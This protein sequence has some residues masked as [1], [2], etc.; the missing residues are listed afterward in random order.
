MRVLLASVFIGMFATGLLHAQD[1]E[2]KVRNDRKNVE[3][4]G[5]W[6]YNDLPKGFS[7]AKKSGKPLLLIIRC[8]PC[9]ACAPA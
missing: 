8:V 1:R 4:D 6:I 2:T 5:Y 7:E 3:G 9:E